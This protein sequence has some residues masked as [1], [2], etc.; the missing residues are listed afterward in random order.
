EVL[1]VEKDA[2]AKSIK[3][4]YK[5]IALANHPDR[6]PDDESAVERF[7][8]AAEAFEVLSDPEK[9]ARYDRFGHAGLQGGGSG[10]HQP[11]FSDVGDIFSMFGD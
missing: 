6:N 2:S 9:R 11:G 3:T 4:S 7:K 5:S 10:T 1:G 8:E